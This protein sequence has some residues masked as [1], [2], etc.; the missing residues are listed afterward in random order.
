MEEH[1]CRSLEGKVHVSNYPVGVED[2][3]PSHPTQV[4]V[5]EEG[6]VVPDYHVVEVDFAILELLVAMVGYLVS[7]IL[8][9]LEDCVVL[10]HA[11]LV[12][13][14]PPKLAQVSMLWL[15]LVLV[16]NRHF[17]LLVKRSSCRVFLAMEATGSRTDDSFEIQN[18]GYPIARVL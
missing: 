5:V 1:L 9:V 11:A 8:F 2:C 4:D 13:Y 18:M 14:M 12:D 15:L 3:I 6:C 16:H 7:M 10:V 17:V